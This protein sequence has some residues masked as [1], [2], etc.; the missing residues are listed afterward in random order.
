MLWSRLPTGGQ[1]EAAVLLPLPGR[2]RVWGGLTGED[3]WASDEMASEGEGEK[4]VGKGER[5]REECGEKLTGEAAADSFGSLAVSPLRHKRDCERPC[6]V[7]RRS[8]THLGDLRIVGVPFCTQ[9]RR[10]WNQTPF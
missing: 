9:R 8:G 2:S 7:P 4:M 10:A 5:E 1:G 3:G 6:S